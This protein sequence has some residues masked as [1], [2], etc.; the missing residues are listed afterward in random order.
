MAQLLP[1]SAPA[2]LL[3]GDGRVVMALLTVVLV[4]PLCTLR[5]IRQVRWWRWAAAAERVWYHCSKRRGRGMEIAENPWL[6][7]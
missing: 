4:L 7:K 5:Q 6:C 2:W 3:A 1:G